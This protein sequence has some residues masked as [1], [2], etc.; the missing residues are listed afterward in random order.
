[1]WTRRAMGW[2]ALVAVAAGTVVGIVVL[3]PEWPLLKRAL[4]GAFLGAG[5]AVILLANRLLR[6]G[7]G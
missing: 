5:V 4:G 6:D 2:F 1:M 7:E 3:E